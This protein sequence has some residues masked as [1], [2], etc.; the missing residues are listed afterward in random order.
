MNKRL[1]QCPICNSTLE[2]IEYHCP[3]CDTVIRGKFGVSD[4]A[5]LSVKQQEFAKVF[6][7]N[8]GNIKEVEKVLGISYPTVKNKLN[9]ITKILCPQTKQMSNDVLDEIEKG[10]ISVDEAIKQLKK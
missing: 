5:M 8:K 7:C 6:I 3:N 10:N 9:E 2:I 4:L 1:K